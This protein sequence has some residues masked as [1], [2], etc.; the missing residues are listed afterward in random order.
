MLP[1]DG[2]TRDLSETGL[3]IVVPSLRIGGHFVN[4]KYCEL[5]IILVELPTGP[6]EIYA[7]PVRYEEPTKDGSKK[8]H[9]ICVEITKISDIDRERYLRYLRSLGG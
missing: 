5:R 8:E 9:L 1:H 2:Y 3:A 7:T 4:S 6:I